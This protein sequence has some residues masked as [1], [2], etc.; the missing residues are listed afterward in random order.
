MQMAFHLNHFAK[1]AISECN[2]LR[3]AG[4]MQNAVVMGI[5]VQ[6]M[7]AI[8]CGMQVYMFKSFDFPFL[9]E[10]L[11][12]Y[13]LSALFLVPAIWSRLAA[14][15]SPDDFSHIKF[16]MSGASALPLALQNT[17]QDMLPNGLQLRVNWGMTETTTAA[18]QPAAKEKDS[19]GSVGRLLPN[20]QAIILSHNG[21]R[22][23][24]GKTGELC[25]KGMCLGHTLLFP[26]IFFWL[27]AF[28]QDPISS[29]STMKTRRLRRELLHPTVGSDPEMLLTYPKKG[30]F[31]L[32]VDQRCV[33]RMM[34]LQVL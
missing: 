27:T 31:S 19:E 22:L 2:Y 1:K 11:T 6:T 12:K 30:N 25:I 3:M 29:E 17:I 33:T 21:T 15:C 32:S 18:S 13:K 34:S 14:Q 20:M 24:T 26:S 9:V 5:T 4:I 16:A 7:L 8:Q 23:G 28:V 10:C